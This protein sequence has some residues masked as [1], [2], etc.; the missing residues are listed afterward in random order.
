MAESCNVENVR[1]CV[2]VES[3]SMHNNTPQKHFAI[4]GEVGDQLIPIIFP[5]A[6]YYACNMQTMFCNSFLRRMQC[7][8]K[9]AQVIH[10]L[11]PYKACSAC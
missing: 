9:T 4:Y 6:E 2:R 10:M 11:Y 1:V 8:Q 3:W 7:N 5:W